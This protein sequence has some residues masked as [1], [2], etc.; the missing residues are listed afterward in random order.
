M[1]GGRLNNELGWCADVEGNRGGAG[2]RVIAWQCHG[3][4]NQR[5][6][7]HPLVRA[8]SVASRIAD[9]AVRRRFVDNAQS[10]A[11]GQLISVANGQLI[12]VDG[13]TMRRAAGSVMVAA[14]RGQL[15]AAG[16]LN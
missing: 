13:G 15:I 11:P 6:K 4:V 9:P 1:S 5:W 12:G 16:G 7:S 10:A 2:A 8:D 14:G 3:G